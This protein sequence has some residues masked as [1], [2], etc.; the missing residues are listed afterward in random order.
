[1]ATSWCDSYQASRQRPCRY[2]RIAVLLGVAYLLSPGIVV[3]H[4][5]GIAPPPDAQRQ[6]NDSIETLVQH[7]PSSVVQILVTGYGSAEDDDRKQTTDVIGR[8]QAVGSGVI[9][10]PEGYIVDQRPRRERGGE[11]RSVRVAAT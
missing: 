10:D 5:A 8:R 11:D 4:A 3:G 7:V 1:M 9:V 2:Q 6:L